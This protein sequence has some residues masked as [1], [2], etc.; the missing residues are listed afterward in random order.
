MNFRRCLIFS[1]KK[2]GRET[3]NTESTYAMA[4]WT[5]NTFIYYFILGYKVGGLGNYDTY[6]T[7]TQRLNQP[8]IT[9]TLQIHTYSGKNF[10]THG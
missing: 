4:G 8:L 1:R 3:E 7:D 2:S 6:A 5:K 10:Q 9:P